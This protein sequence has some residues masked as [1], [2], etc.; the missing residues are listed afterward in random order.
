[1]T[2]TLPPQPKS[3]SRP[4][5]LIIGLVTAVVAVLLCGGGA[6]SFYLQGKA[7]QDAPVREGSHTVELESGE[8]TAIWSIQPNGCS[9]AGPDGP[10]ID[11]SSATMSVDSEDGEIHRIFA[12]DATQSGSYE[13]TCSGPFV[14][15]ESL[16]VG[17]LLPAAI[18]A[19]LGCLSIVVIIIGLVLWL[20]RRR[21]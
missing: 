11:S 12:I 10:V 15:A 21:A 20:V 17:G 2:P 9:V 14:V 18:G 7:V 19:G 1:M 3:S 13:I 8:S 6:G 4:T 16:S 5:V